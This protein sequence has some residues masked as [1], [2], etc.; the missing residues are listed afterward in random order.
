MAY[1]DSKSFQEFI[2]ENR[3]IGFFDEPITLKSGRRSY[4]YVNWRTVSEDVWLMD[5]LSDFVLDFTRDLKQQNKISA[6]PDTFYGVPEGA[7]KLGLLTQYKLARSNSCSKGSHVFSMGRGKP[8]EHGVSKD[9]YFIGEPRGATIVLEDV[10]TTGGSLL[11]TI[12]QLLSADVNVI[13]A[14][15]LTNRMEKSD[16]GKSVTELVSEKKSNGRSVPYFYMSSAIELLPQIIKR[17]KPA[18]HIVKS[19]QE[20]FKSWGVAELKL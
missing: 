11:S 3:V 8:K 1:F 14:Y 10:T 4:W 13:A 17:E 6:S 19:I 12:D 9:R 5:K 7:T 15:G 16:S 2:I 18:P 20:E